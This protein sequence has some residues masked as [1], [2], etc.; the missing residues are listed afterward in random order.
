MRHHRV[1]RY[2]L[3]SFVLSASALVGLNGLQSHG[4][5]APTRSHVLA[6]SGYPPAPLP[7]SI[8]VSTL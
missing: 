6:D 3:C 7:L 8:Y 1:L 4:L 5:A 2:I